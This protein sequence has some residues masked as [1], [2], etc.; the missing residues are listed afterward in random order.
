MAAVV[1]ILLWALALSLARLHE[2]PLSA[3]DI[4]RML[5]DRDC[6]IVYRFEYEGN[7]REL[8]YAWLIIASG[9][10]AV[11]FFREANLELDH[12]RTVDYPMGPATPGFCV[13]LANG[14]LQ[15][16]LY[17][18]SHS[19]SRCYATRVDYQEDMQLHTGDQYDTQGSQYYVILL[20][21]Q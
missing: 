21:Q 15:Y 4:D 3:S 9:D 1:I 18:Q 19:R 6:K 7:S 12:G 20:V 17:S 11:A 16:D 13:S 5:A 10:S 2:N 14:I 8:V